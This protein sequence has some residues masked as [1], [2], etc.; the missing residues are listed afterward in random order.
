MG[1]LKAHLA[2]VDHDTSITELSGC[3]RLHPVN[4][5]NSDTKQRTVVAESAWRFG[6]YGIGFP[7]IGAGVLVGIFWLLKLLGRWLLSIDGG[8]MHKP[9]TFLNALP[10]PG[11]TIGIA[12]VGAIIGLVLVFIA[13][14]ESLTITFTG[15]RVVFTAEGQSQEFAK[16]DIEG[17]FR[18]GKEVVLLGRRTEELTQHA[19]D[20]KTASIA[21]AFTSHGYRWFDSDP[22]G[23][24]F[25]R[26]VPD[27]PGT[28]D[29]A[30]ALLKARGEILAGKS[31][32]KTE[33][34]ELLTELSALGVV[35]RDRNKRQYW[36]MARD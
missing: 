8:P 11:V 35:V 33:L 20:L 4:R 32:S 6:A 28:S 34:R 10:E 7:V 13:K 12:A 14:H 5:D 21:D 2:G 1:D 36:R 27:T 19:S 17:A 15:D 16:D 25:E 29:R 9:A 3:N 18:E 23:N 26:W 22:Y 24:E 30:N 31:P